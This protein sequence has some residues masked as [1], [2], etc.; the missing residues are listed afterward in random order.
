MSMTCINEP[1]LKVIVVEDMTLPL[2]HG[3]A[4]NPYTNNTDDKQQRHGRNGY[5]SLRRLVYDP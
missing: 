2:C 1:A 5:Q 3:L 4:P